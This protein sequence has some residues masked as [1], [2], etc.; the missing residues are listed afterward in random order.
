[1]EN[2]LIAFKVAV[3][4]IFGAIAEFLGWKV[5][6]ALVLAAAM[7][8][9]WISGT[10]AAKKNGEWS[11]AIAR[12]GLYHKSGI[13]YVILVACIVDFVISMICNEIPALESAWPVV[14]FPLACLWY[15]I[16]ELGS[17]LENAV[18]LGA[19]V[20]TWLIKSLKIGADIIKKSGD[21]LMEKAEE[22]LKSEEAD[23]E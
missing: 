18:K 20:P 4:A 10:W 17:I 5:V 2:K 7:C 19:N 9:D 16:T 6:M 15:I 3:F 1:M 13:L 12:E 14:F 11:S 23:N 22:K 8:A 21:A